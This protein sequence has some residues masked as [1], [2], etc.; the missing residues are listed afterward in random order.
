LISC[1]DAVFSY[2]GRHAACD[3]NFEV[4]Q[5][6]YLCI[7]GSN[8]SGKSTLLRGLLG[9]K[10]PSSGTL[11]YAEN[12]KS[13][14]IGYLPQQSV[15]NRDFP[16]SAWE[17]VLS[18]CLAA[19]GLMPFYTARD[20]RKALQNLA[21]LQA[22]DLRKR[23][24][25]EL[26]V[27]QRQRLLLARA[28]CAAERLLVLDEPTAGL[29]PQVTRDVYQA[30]AELNSREG[31]TVIMVSHDVESALLYAS[32]ILHLQV[33]QMFFG[34]VE[35]YRRSGVGEGFLGCQHV[36]SHDAAEHEGRGA[37][38]HGVGAA[39]GHEGRGA[40]GHEGRGATEYESHDA[41]ERE[42]HSATE[43]ENHIAA[44]P[45]ETDAHSHD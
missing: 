6:D 40:V 31:M 29:D 22:T 32:H 23:S 12:L 18:G 2:E 20:K 45:L 39:A 44:E 10:A 21:L 7:V 27:G 28:L 24:F 3:L 30:I 1:E 15:T 37:I 4:S 41:L 43:H 13:N 16:A 25:Y 17:V 19:H 34:S 33:H 35:R 14:Q 38:E 26:S 9:L 11:R 5:G 8:G 42:S 36:E